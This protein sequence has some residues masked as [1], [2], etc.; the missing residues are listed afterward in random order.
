MNNMKP[1]EFSRQE[2]RFTFSSS[3]GIGQTDAAATD[4]AVLLHLINENFSSFHTPQMKNKHFVAAFLF[5]VKASHQ[6]FL[7]KPEA[8]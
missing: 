5:S 3:S 7:Q 1:S 8:F 6:P 2:G 4:C